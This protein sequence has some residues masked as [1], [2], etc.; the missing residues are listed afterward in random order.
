MSREEL[1]G[2]NRRVLW[3]FCLVLFLTACAA[4]GSAF[5]LPAWAGFRGWVGAH[6]GEG[7]VQ[8]LFGLLV[9][10]GVLAPFLLVPLLSLLWLDRRFGLRCPRCKCSVTLRCRPWMALRSGRCCLCGHVLFEP[11]G[12][13]RP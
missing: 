3:Y 7:A 11:G 13:G 6:R 4:I 12:T 9:T 10:G 5:L 1:I 2:A 8:F